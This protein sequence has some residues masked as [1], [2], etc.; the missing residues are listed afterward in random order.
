[1]LLVPKACCAQVLL[2][3]LAGVFCVV[4]AATKLRNSSCESAL[5]LFPKYGTKITVCTRIYHQ[6]RRHKW[7]GVQTGTRKWWVCVS[8]VLSP[9]RSRMLRSCHVCWLT[10]QTSAGLGWTCGVIAC[11]CWNILCIESL[12]GFLAVAR[13]FRCCGLFIK[14]EKNFHSEM[15]GRKKIGKERATVPASVFCH[16]SKDKS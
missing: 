10:V 8:R 14:R 6:N 9:T 15:Q 13:N 12:R 4:P 11:H 7:W 3:R 1:M 5:L 2:C 16:S